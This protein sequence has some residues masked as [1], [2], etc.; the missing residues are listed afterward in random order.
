[1]VGKDAWIW[2]VQA[3]SICIAKK[4]FVPSVFAFF[5]SI[6]RDGE[7][8]WGK[9]PLHGRF[10]RL[11]H[12]CDANANAKANANRKKRVHTANANARK[13]RYASVVEV[14][15]Q[16]GRQR[17]IFCRFTCGKQTQMQARENENLFVPC[18]DACVCMCICVG[19][20][21]ISNSLHLHLHL[22][23]RSLR[24]SLCRW[25]TEG[26]VGTNPFTLLGN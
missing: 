22:R 15:F 13:E 25:L 6:L 20:V 2:C 12:T 19:V 9:E 14:L 18:V 4:D 23:L 17:L 11:V 26:G 5:R 16:D 24:F 8:K 21:H 10:W 1:M 3:A 7:L